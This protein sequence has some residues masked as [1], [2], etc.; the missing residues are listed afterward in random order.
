[1]ALHPSQSATQPSTFPSFWVTIHKLAYNTDKDHS[2]NK[3]GQQACVDMLSAMQQ[4]IGCPK[5]SRHMKRFMR[6]H[7]V[8]QPGLRRADQWTYF[9]YTHAFHN[10]VNKRLG[11]PQMQ[12][13][14][15]LSRYDSQIESPTPSHGQNNI[16]ASNP[17]V[18]PVCVAGACSLL[19][20]VVA[21]VL[22]R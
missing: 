1:M 20:S 2:G 13:E 6:A 11:K 14:E 9:K 22:E 17:F 3:R 10:D 8:P 5:C 18:V 12:F 21:A 19:F 7:A 15:A 16:V 4:L